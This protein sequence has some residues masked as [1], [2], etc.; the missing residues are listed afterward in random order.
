[1]GHPEPVHLQPP[2]EQLIVQVPSHW[3]VQLPPEQLKS[4]VAFSRHHAEQS[5]P[6]QSIVHGTL[7]AQ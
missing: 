7:S 5:P 4:H 1:V 6:E 2:L 3:N